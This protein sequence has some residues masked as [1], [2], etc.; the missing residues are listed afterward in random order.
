[1]MRVHHGNPHHEGVGFEDSEFLSWFFA[2]GM[3]NWHERG[4]HPRVVTWASRKI[5]ANASA[6]KKIGIAT[7]Q[8]MACSS[9]IKVVLF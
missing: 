6:T 9:K 1:M 8:N 7:S 2:F 5:Q 3:P 4:P